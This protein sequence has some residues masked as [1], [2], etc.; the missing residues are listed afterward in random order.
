MDRKQNLFI[1][2]DIQ[3]GIC[4]H[5]KRL[6]VNISEA[7]KLLFI[8]NQNRSGLQVSRDPAPIPIRYAPQTK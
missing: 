2:A 5:G 4:K 8:L 6:N 3:I 1:F 7:T